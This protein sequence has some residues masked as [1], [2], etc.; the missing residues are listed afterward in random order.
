[1]SVSDRGL[2][3]STGGVEKGKIGGEKKDFGGREKGQKAVHY[4]WL[5]DSYFVFAL[6]Q[7]VQIIAQQENKNT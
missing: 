6:I 2:P 5:S 7:T 1:M 4:L 3:A